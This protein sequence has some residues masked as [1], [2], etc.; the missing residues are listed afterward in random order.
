MATNRDYTGLIRTPPSI[1][2]LITQRAR[3]KGEIDR[4]QRLERTLPERIRVAEAKLAALDTV[5]PFH[6]VKVDPQIIK[7]RRPKRPSA[8]P[9]GAITKFMLGELKLAE[10]KPM[11]TKEIVL[12]FARQFDIDH[13]VVSH[14]DL[15]LRLKARLCSLVNQGIVR[16]HHS[17]T[18]ASGWGSWSLVDDDRDKAGS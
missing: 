12:K 9:Y 7:G 1:S 13:S 10:G 6:E 15:M 16:R 5:I 8:A 2:W 18:M 14:T 4:L 3:F 11:Y 17:T